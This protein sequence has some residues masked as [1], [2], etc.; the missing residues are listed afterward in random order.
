MILNLKSSLKF[1][2]FYL[3]NLLIKPSKEIKTNSLLLIRLDAIGDYIMF[4]DFIREIKG[5][6]AFNRCEI[7]FLGNLAW[8]SLS[9]ELDKQFV[10]HFIWLDR[11]R[12]NQ[13]LFYR[14]SKLTEITSNGYSV[15][16]L[17][18]YSRDFYVSDTIVK[19][20]SA[21]KK[22]G[23]IGNLSNIKSW[24]KRISDKYYDRLIEANEGVMFEFYRNKEFVE[25]LLG[26]EVNI[27]KPVL[28]LSP[29]ESELKLPKK[30]AVLFIGASGRER[31][32]KIEGFAEV[33]NYLADHC[34]YEIVL[35]G[36]PNDEE[37]ALKFSKQ[38]NGKYIDLVGKTSL[39]DLLYVIESSSL[40]VSNETSVPHFAAALN[41]KNIF[42]IYNGSHLGRF[43]PYP[44]SASRH[45]HVIYHS[46]ID[47][48]FDGYKR[49]S[50]SY[51][52][53]VTLDINDISVA[54]VINKLDSKMLT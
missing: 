13:D 3:M 51:G 39:F 50:N 15:V 25:N 27:N 7:T 35:C 40:I 31:K 37:D 23:S 19:L 28:Q 4:R 9:V 5:N 2:V 52:F 38:F 48:D 8:K 34:G 1:V 42:V 49:L 46:E 47:K 30:Y 11:D 44:K 53:K 41:A 14:Y 10:D 24:Q 6:A 16:L 21:N 45:Y 22:I 20:V 12:F 17:P 54:S 26:V 36:A 43:L 29:K 32:W 18:T 33:G